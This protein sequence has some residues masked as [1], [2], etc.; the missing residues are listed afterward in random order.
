VVAQLA[1]TH[2]RVKRSR[3]WFIEQVS[4]V[5]Y[6]AILIARLTGMVLSPRPPKA[7]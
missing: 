6:V 2:W 4:G 1:S 7:D 5:M 3:S